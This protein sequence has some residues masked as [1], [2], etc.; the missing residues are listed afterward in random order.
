M[1]VTRPLCSLTRADVCVCFVVVEQKFKA[2]SCPLRL[3]IKSALRTFAAALKVGGGVVD[4]QEA[5]CQK[6]IAFTDEIAREAAK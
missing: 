5:A 4:V 6:L 3:R 1:H 2:G